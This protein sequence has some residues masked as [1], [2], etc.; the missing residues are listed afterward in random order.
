MN[1][2]GLG[3]TICS[4]ISPEGLSGVALI[5]LTGPKSKQIIHEFC[6]FLPTN[7]SSHSLKVGHFVSQGLSFTDE[8]VV[9][10]FA[11]GRSFTGEET[12]EISCH[13]N[14]LC[15]NKILESLVSAGAKR[16]QRGEFTWMAVENG[17]MDLSQAESLFQIIHSS[18]DLLLQKSF[19][20]YSNGLDVSIK[21][22][23]AELISLIAQLEAQIDYSEEAISIVSS[24]MIQESLVDLQS[25]LSHFLESSSTFQKENDVPLILFYGEPNVGKSSLLNKL[26]DSEIA[27]V[28]EVAGTTRDPVVHRTSI[29]GR[30]VHFVDTAGVRD[31]SDSIEL[32]GIQKTES[33]LKSASLVLYLSDKNDF[34]VLD[35]VDNENIFKI[36]TKQDL[37]ESSELVNTYDKL[38]FSTSAVSGFGLDLLKDKIKS[39]LL[40]SLAVANRNVFSVWQLDKLNLAVFELKEAL[41]SGPSF[42]EDIV[43]IHLN[44][45]LRALNE[46]SFIDDPEQVRDVIFSKFCL[47]K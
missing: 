27:I 34:S 28:S 33:L 25:R 11:K 37:S 18:N 38:E 32:Q 17:R 35:L 9:S 43:L 23:K 15:Y 30:P 2:F 26:F 21:S 40:N 41:S 39:F 13:G 3:R 4:L 44:S 7:L 31:S 1:S 46:L 42:A 45:A 6:K 10:Y 14:P 20:S 47:G 24:D 19:L 22:I 16:A 8:V 29:S 5:R 36:H 12:F